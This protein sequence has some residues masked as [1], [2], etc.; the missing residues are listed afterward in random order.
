MLATF[1]TASKLAL[2][3]LGDKAPEN[4]PP[5]DFLYRLSILP[6]HY[7]RTFIL[8]PSDCGI[9][10]SLPYDNCIHYCFSHFQFPFLY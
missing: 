3:L 6:R 9:L 8:V 10:F 1:A 7:L 4:S 2:R 5:W